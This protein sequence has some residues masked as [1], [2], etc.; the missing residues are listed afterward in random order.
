M[1]HRPEEVARHT[2][3]QNGGEY[4]TDIPDLLS[5]FGHQQLTDAAR[6][7][8]RQALQS[9]GVGTDPDLLVAQGRDSVRLFLLDVVQV[10]A[11]RSGL[12]RLRPRTWKGWVGYAFAALLIIIA[13]TPESKDSSEPR[14]KTEAVENGGAQAQ[15]AEDAAAE[16]KAERVELRRERAK[17]REQRA[18][19]RRERAQIRRQRARARRVAAARRE[20][21]QEL[22]AA[23][24]AAAPPEPEPEVAPAAAACH[25]SYDPC[26]KPDATDY[27]CAGG[28]GDGPEYTGFVT[29]TGSDDYDLD[30]DGD[31]TGCE[32]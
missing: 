3:E 16:A 13:L 6:Q 20:R 1:Q 26:L 7:E 2:V 19:L 17:L 14:T 25:P 32:S 21:K 31:G 28:S 10:R 29:V 27:D 15:A 9:V 22:A 4:A 30:S 23:A 24:A 5:L 18:E 8:V 11:A 12:S